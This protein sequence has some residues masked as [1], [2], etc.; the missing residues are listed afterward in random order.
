M[1]INSTIKENEKKK[2]IS[3]YIMWAIVLAFVCALFLDILA[4][5]IVI[6]AKIIFQYWYVAIIIVLIIIFFKK[7]RRK[8]K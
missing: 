7:R 2:D 1:K 3:K 5:L 6:A 4:K 8:K